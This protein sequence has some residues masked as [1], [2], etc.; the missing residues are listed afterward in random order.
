MDWLSN[1]IG[2]DW[3]RALA[4]FVGINVGFVVV[5]MIVAYTVLAERRV[6]GF[7]QGRLGPNRVG[8]GGMFQPFADLLKFIFKEE[9]TPSASTRFVY[10][11]APII[12]ITAAL[13]PIIVYPFG[14]EVWL[15]FLG[16]FPLVIARFDI[17]L[18]Y[19]L[20]IT[21]VGVYGV[22]L[23]GW[24][25]NSK[26]S[27]M[28]GLRAASQMISYE[29]SLGLSLV[30]V[31]L[32]SGT[33]NLYDIVVQQGGGGGVLNWNIWSFWKAGT[34]PQIIGFITYLIS[35]I[36]ET[37][38]VPFDLPEAETELVA[39]FHTE[40]SA[41]KFALFFMA[42]YVNM[43]TVSMLAT[44]LFL[45]GWQGPFVDVFPWIGIVWFLLKVVFFLFL[46]IWLRGTLP[47]FRFDQLMN[48]GWKFLLPV[49]IINVILTATVLYF[50]WS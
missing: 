36:A 47:R 13:M 27:L 17:A 7:I 15:P 16:T 46:Y 11:L 33:L 49:A 26:Y 3:A 22:A 14:P 50:R 23:A 24:S 5:L 40:Y 19:V 21:S 30:G 39:G 45:G 29:L 6:L 31:V 38:R 41:L 42:E 34:C 10:F 2:A 48:F 4:Q 37:N 8:P 18:L 12:A 28:G 9:I 25:S 1:Q 35:A 44:T 32:M 43:F 20:G